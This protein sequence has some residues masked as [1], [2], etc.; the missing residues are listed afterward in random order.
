MGS[1][2]KK[3]TPK[4]PVSTAPAV[5]A[6]TKKRLDQARKLYRERV[7]SLNSRNK[8]N[9]LIREGLDY[10]ELRA[11]RR[12]AA[13]AALLDEVAAVAKPICPDVPEVMDFEYEWMAQ[14]IGARPAFDWNERIC[15]TVLAAAMWMLDHLR[16]HG[17]F[18]DAC[19]LFPRDERIFEELEL[20]DIWD[21]SHE[22]DALYAMSWIIHHRNDDCTGIRAADKEQLARP[23]MDLYTAANQHRQEV[24]SRQV[25]EKVLTMIPPREIERAVQLFEKT[26]WEL[27]RRYYINRNV[28]S[29]LQQKIDA[30]FSSYARKTE[31]L[32]ED[33]KGATTRLKQQTD[34]PP[35]VLAAR[36]P[37]EQN[38]LPNMHRAAQERSELLL[39]AKQL[40]EQEA[41][42][43]EEQAQLDFAMQAYLDTLGD[44]LTIP[45]SQRDEMYYSEAA[46]IWEGYTISDPYSL[47]FAFLYLLDQ[48]SDLP[49]VYA[50]S[51]PLMEQCA[52]VLPWRYEKFEEDPDDVWEHFDEERD[53]YVFGHQKVELPKRIKVPELEDWYGTLYENVRE[54]DPEYR[55]YR[56]LAQIVYE[57]TGSV[58]PRNLTRYESALTELDYYGINGKK[59]LHPLLYCMTMLGELRHRTHVYQ[60]PE[61]TAD[62]SD[63]VSV[64]ELQEK[65]RAL[66]TE[67]KQLRQA[68]YEAG[69]ETKELRKKLEA[70]EHAAQADRQ[71]L[72]DLRSLVFNRQEDSAEEPTGK[73]EFPYTAKSRIVVFGGHDSWAKEIK[74]RLPN[75]RFIDRTMLPNAQ[76]IRQADTIWIQTNALSHAFFYKIITEA[77]KYE[78][79]VRYFSFA[80]AEKCAEQLALGDMG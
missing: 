78:I 56:N 9:P 1:K 71:E 19:K 65:L 74:P 62:I 43:E 41:V 54:N 57:L 38:I 27:V 47:C 73:V 18:F 13:S 55:E 24:P 68:A 80:S 11:K 44:I 42:L 49:W 76:L 31:M 46:A 45:K 8:Q 30:K 77:R 50:I 35:L 25:F 61:E 7:R 28:Y 72:A 2:K 32:A 26:W 67:N 48:G 37:W 14:N 3:Q 63:N 5:D 75:V 52:S 69:R 66:Q 16:E 17:Y 22:E 53:D 12:M 15:S 39:R 4:K 36:H 33:L 34:T 58:M 64:E 10:D 79:P 70:S 29:Q 20:P 40:E 21:T 59:A 60:L 51:L 23:Y 6:V